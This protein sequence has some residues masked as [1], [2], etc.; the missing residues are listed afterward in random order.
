MALLS[1]KKTFVQRLIILGD[2]MDI[3]NVCSSLQTMSISMDCIISHPTRRGI[4]KDVESLLDKHLRL[5]QHWLLTLLQHRVSILANSL[6]VVFQ[7][8]D[9]Y[10]KFI[11]LSFHSDCFY[12]YVKIVSDFKNRLWQMY[13][14]HRC[15]KLYKPATRSPYNSHLFSINQ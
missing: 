7:Y 6:A 3:Q 8:E 12:Y 15:N 5:V 11:C 2:N 10:E 4:S 1:T 14:V 9:V 13:F